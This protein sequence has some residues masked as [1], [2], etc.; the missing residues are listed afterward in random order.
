MSQEQM[1]AKISERLEKL[2]KEKAP[3]VSHASVNVQ[4]RVVLDLHEED[5]ANMDPDVKDFVTNNNVKVEIWT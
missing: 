5:W 2:L 3:F 1:L 4:L